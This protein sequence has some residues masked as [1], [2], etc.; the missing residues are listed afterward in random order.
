MLASDCHQDWAYYG[1]FQAAVL[2][3]DK[4]N[5]LSKKPNKISSK[6]ISTRKKALINLMERCCL[7][8][9]LLSQV[10][11]DDNVDYKLCWLA[12][13]FLASQMQQK[14]LLARQK[15]TSFVVCPSWLRVA[16]FREGRFKKTCKNLLQFRKLI[17]MRKFPYWWHLQLL[18]KP[19]YCD[20]NKKFLLYSLSV[21][22]LWYKDH[23]FEGQFWNSVFL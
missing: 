3:K 1:E 9:L 17:K 16:A 22:K 7:F 8:K 19:W 11:Q 23:H 18:L 13:S 14:I 2:D 21:L 20:N 5:F 12:R 6:I 15:H 10:N 4:F